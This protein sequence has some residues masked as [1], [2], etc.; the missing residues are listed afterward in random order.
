[1]LDRAREY[2]KRGQTDLA[3]DKLQQIVKVYRGTLAAAYAQAALD[4]PRQNLPLFPEGPYVLAEKTPKRSLRRARARNLRRRPGLDRTRP[5][6]LRPRCR[7]RRSPA[8]THRAVPRRGPT[9]RG[10][11]VRV[12][13]RAWWPPPSRPLE[14]PSGAAGPAPQ[15]GPPPIRAWPAPPS[16][17]SRRESG[18]GGRDRPGRSEPQSSRPGRPGA[19]GGPGDGS[20][21][22]RQRTSSEYAGCGRGT[23]PS[24]PA[25][26]PG[27][28]VGGPGQPA[29][30]PPGPGG[31][32]GADPREHRRQ[33]S[34]DAAGRAERQCR[35]PGRQ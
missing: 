34:R 21:C 35:P 18:G 16:A 6:R 7:R 23:I 19:G 9:F 22:R 30:P 20:E 17:R 12:R 1:M 27:P 33:R 13:I 24:A 26:G 28:G 5:G 15:P 25:P 4:R 32:R 8:S 2:A 10:P 14:S 11:P 31:C 29:P 3:L